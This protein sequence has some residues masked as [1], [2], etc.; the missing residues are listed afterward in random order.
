MII[1]PLLAAAIGIFFGVIAGLLPGIHINLIGAVLVSSSAFLLGIFPP[2]YVILFIVSMA[3]TQT[4]VDFIPSIFLGAPDE[5][6]V[7]SVL[8]GHKLL[9]QGKGYEAILYS[10]YGCLFSIPATILISILFI[11]YLSKFESTINFLIPYILI[12]SSIFLISREQNKIPAILVF[13]MSGFLGIAVLNSGINQSFLPLLTGLFGA[14]SLIISIKNKVEIPPQKIT[15]IKIKKRKLIRPILL[16]SIFSPLCCFLPG[17]GSGQSAVISASISRLG[18]KGFLVLL[19]ATNMIGISLSFVVFYAIGKTRTGM[20]STIGQIIGELN[21]NLIIIIL[22]TICLVGIV[23]FYLTLYL[24]KIFS[25]KITSLNYTK[26]SLITLAFIS[27]IVLWFSGIF[28]FFIFLISTATGIFGILSNVK[29]INLMG[30][31]VI[32]VI[33]FYLL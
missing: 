6:T 31:L 16:S 28:G 5:T 17:F 24:A 27:A 21:L 1:E 7:L 4:F 8:P 3:V 14:S 32:P 30:C 22:L 10:S 25:Q 29:R 23:C 26:L 19:G 11:K 2:I 13:L 18:K 33:L 20:A 9:K 12:I 15:S